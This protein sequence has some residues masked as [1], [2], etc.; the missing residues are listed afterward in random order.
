MPGSFLV[1][2]QGFPVPS[3]SETGQLPAGITFIDNQDG[4][5]TLAGTPA[6]GTSKIY[7]INIAANNGVGAPTTQAFTLSVNSTV[8]ITSGSA[9]T[10]TVGSAGF[11]SI[12]T[13]GSPAPS[14]TQTGKLPTGVTFVDNGNGTATLSGTPAAGAANSYLLAITASN[15]VGSNATATLKERPVTLLVPVEM[16][17]AALWRGALT[18]PSCGCD[19][20][21]RSAPV[22]DWGSIKTG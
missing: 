10:F 16:T 12:T 8:A 9:T 2:T 22:D 19:G 6:V 14:L 1:T 18:S 21:N 5:A 15:G 3:L 20:R 11:F 13:M 7:A 4:T 17:R